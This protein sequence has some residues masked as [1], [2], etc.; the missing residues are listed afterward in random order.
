VKYELGFYIPEDDIL[1]SHC[2]GNLRSYEILSSD[3]RFVL[4]VSIFPFGAQPPALAVT[5]PSVP[6]RTNP[7][8][9]GAARAACNVC[10]PHYTACSVPLEGIV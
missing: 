9:R 8:W 6:A 3:V 4:E 7:L 2:R 5:A 1:Y 10:T